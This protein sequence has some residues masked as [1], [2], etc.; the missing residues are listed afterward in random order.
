MGTI[1]YTSGNCY[2]DQIIRRPSSLS[3]VSLQPQDFPL[4]ESRII[5]L[6]RSCFVWKCKSGSMCSY[7]ERFSKLSRVSAEGLGLGFEVCASLRFV[8]FLQKSLLTFCSAVRC[9]NEVWISISLP[10]MSDFSILVLSLLFIPTS[11]HHSQLP[12][13]SG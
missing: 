9:C 7:L 4:L 10:F 6:H 8:Q 1:V 5:A 3:S 12:V 2:S 11:S 13:H